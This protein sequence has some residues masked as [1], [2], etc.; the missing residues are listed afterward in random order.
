MRAVLWTYPKG[1][2][3]DNLPSGSGKSPKGKIAVL[4]RARERVSMKSN[5]PRRASEVCSFCKSDRPDATGRGRQGME[6]DRVMSSRILTTG[7]S[8]S[9]PGAAMSAR[10]AFPL[11][12][13]M[14]CFTVWLIAT[15]VLIFDQIKF[16]AKAELLEQAA[17]ALRGPQVMVPTERPS[18]LPSGA[19]M[20]RL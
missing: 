16:D 19:K 3:T 11:R 17:R 1:G 5:D 18:N 20:E 15:E 13:L 14:V 6:V 8:L 7:D 4:C 10:R 9:D 2:I 12:T